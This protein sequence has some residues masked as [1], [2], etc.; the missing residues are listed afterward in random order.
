MPL[1][2]S[3]IAALGVNLRPSPPM[4]KI[5]VRLVREHSFPL[6]LQNINCFLGNV[7]S[8]NRLYILGRKPFLKRALKCIT[9]NKM[10]NILVH[11]EDTAL[12]I[13]STKN[14]VSTTYFECTI[15]KVPYRA[16]GVNLRRWPPI[17]K[18]SVR[19]AR[20]HCFPLN[21]KKINCF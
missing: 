4:W 21:P 18:I 16:L 8:K 2:K 7:V 11:Y 13:A 17:W 1:G 5:S 19:L 20:E 12:V 10:K 14:L 3:H 6:N 15:R 9:L